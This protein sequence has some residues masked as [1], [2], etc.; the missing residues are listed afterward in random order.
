MLRAHCRAK[1]LRLVLSEFVRY[2]QISGIDVAVALTLDRPTDEVTEVV[3]D[4]L[5]KIDRVVE[6]EFPVVSPDGGDRFAEA[7]RIQY[8]KQIVPMEPDWV[9]FADAV[10]NPHI[11]LWYAHTLFIWDSPRLYNPDRHHHSPILFRFDEFSDFP[12]HRIIQAP[13]P[14]H[15]R[16]LLQNRVETLRTPLLDYSTLKRE[17]RARLHEVF[18]AAGKDDPYIQS[19]VGNPTLKELPA[20]FPDLWSHADTIQSS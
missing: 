11:D 15:D 20:D 12:K 7:N 17:E 13:N 1:L 18:L 16:A 9:I 19:L 8:R 6:S 10:C 3:R 5:P 14:L 2:N 4:F